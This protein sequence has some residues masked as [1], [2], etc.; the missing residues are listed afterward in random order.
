MAR[1]TVDIDEHLLEE[2]KRLTGERTTKGAVNEALRRLVRKGH[3]KELGKLMG[4]GIV[5]M[6][7]EEL[8]ELRAD[9]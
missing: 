2:A 1:T 4:S 8:E 5:K 9:E 3:L 6:T 7:P